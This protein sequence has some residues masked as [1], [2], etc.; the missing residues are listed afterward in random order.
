MGDHVDRARSALDAGCDLILACND[1]DA[2]V[3]IFR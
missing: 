3:S 1:I 2:A